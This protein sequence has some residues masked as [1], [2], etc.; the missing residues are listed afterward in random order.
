[1]RKFYDEGVGPGDLRDFIASCIQILICTGLLAF[2]SLALMGNR[3]QGWLSI[4]QFWIL[5]AVPVA[6]AG[7]LTQ[8]RLTQWQARKR[9]GSYAA[10][11]IGAAALNVTLS[12]LLVV[13]MACGVEGRLAAITAASVTCASLALL[14]L[15]RDRLLGLLSWRPQFHAEIFRFGIPL[16]PHTVG[17]FLLMSAD[18]FVVANEFG[19]SEA[20]VYMVA[21]QLAS[22]PAML[23]DALNK[24]YVPWLF[25]RLRKDDPNEMQAIVRNTY[26]WF[27]VILIGAASV[28]AAGGAILEFVAGGGYA[29]AGDVLG[30]LVLGQVFGGM[31]LMVTNYIFY[32][33]RTGLLGASTVACGALHILLLVAFVRW[34]GLEG[35]AM[36]F[37]ISMAL[38]FL[39][40]W[41]IAHLRRP[42]PWFAW[43]KPSES[44]GRAL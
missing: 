3:L 42:M 41:R 31:Y 34:K 39:V 20:G 32:S 19:L 10:F 17:I 37:A 35:A 23:F 2:L 14:F 24:A 36:A 6:T 15:H 13:V 22:A 18:R 21:V 7:F 28:F 38:R 5:A 9:V 40:T 4:D 12:L 11:Q 44:A 16:I 1:M 43:R 27:L 29:H 8:L 25:E 26:L 30:W 33:K